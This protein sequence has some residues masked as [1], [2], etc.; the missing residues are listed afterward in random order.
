MKALQ[1]PAS[2]GLNWKFTVKASKDANEVIVQSSPFALIASSGSFEFEDTS[3][4]KTRQHMSY[5]S[6]DIVRAMIWFVHSGEV[7]PEIKK[8][9]QVVQ[10]ADLAHQLEIEPLKDI[11]VSRAMHQMQ[12]QDVWKVL[13][14]GSDVDEL[15]GYCDMILIHD[16][17]KCL[18]IEYF[19]HVQEIDLK[20]FL[21]FP[22]MNIDSEYDLVKAVVRLHE[23]TG[24]RQ[25][26]DL[27]IP[28]LRL[29]TLERHQLEIIE[30]YLNQ[31]EYNAILK[32]HER[33]QEAMLPRRI[34]PYSYK[35]KRP[36]MPNSLSTCL[37]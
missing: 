31:F 25:L 23:A 30:E 27:A 13:A 11:F 17:Q 20:Y 35:R 33:R 14:I 10:M 19:K 2:L 3:D 36:A 34:C 22:A 29:L 28:H 32:W 5:V 15:R 18:D 7:D 12:I 21:D 6:A 8:L 37:F 24:N 9:D 4:L 1:D 16:T 26:V